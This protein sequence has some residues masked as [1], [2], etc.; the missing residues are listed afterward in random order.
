[1]T[2]HAQQLF[3]AKNKTITFE[4]QQYKHYETH[5]IRKVTWLTNLSTSIDTLQGEQDNWL[6]QNIFPSNN[7]ENFK[8]PKGWGRRLDRD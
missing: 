6:Q 7:T 3:I 1:M 2:S 4:W 5:L 8:R